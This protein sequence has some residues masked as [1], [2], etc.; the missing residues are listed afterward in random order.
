MQ[1]IL[2][3]TLVS[4]LFVLNGKSQGQK[5][6]SPPVSPEAAS[7][8]KASQMPVGHF[9]G[10][11]SVSVP[12]F[13]I[14]LND[15]EWPISLS[16][17]TGGIK[18]EEMASCAGLGWTLNATGSVNQTING[19]NDLLFDGYPNAGDKLSDYYAPNP[20]SGPNYTGGTAERRKYDAYK[21]IAEGQ[22][23]WQPDLF[24]YNAGAFS[25]KFFLDQ[26]GQTH[27]SPF[28]QLKTASVFGSHHLTSE[29][30]VEYAFDD[31]EY[32][33]YGACFTDNASMSN[34]LTKIKT[35]NG[36]WLSFF[37]DTLTYSYVARNQ[38]MICMKMYGVEFTGESPCTM[39]NCE[40]V[41]NTVTA[42]I[43]KKIISS[44][45]D[46]VTF[47][48]SSQPR[49]DIINGKVL[50]SVQVFNSLH[51]RV[52]KLNLKHSYIG[53]TDS[54][55]ACRLMLDS[56]K[57][58]ST[59]GDE[60]LLYAYEYDNL[61]PLPD[62][63]SKSQDV[64][65]YYNGQANNTLLP[66]RLDFNY[67]GANRSI[68]FAYAKAGSLKK[69]TYSTGGY[70]SFEYEPNDHY[71]SN[72]HVD[73]LGY[74]A[75]P[76][77][78]SSTSSTVSYTVTIPTNAANITLL[79]YQYGCVAT[80]PPDYN[81]NCLITFSGNGEY[82]EWD[83]AYPTNEEM[84]NIPAGSYTV[85][86][87]TTGGSYGHF[88]VKY[89][90]DHSYTFTGNLPTGGLR[91][92]STSIATDN[93][94]V[95]EVIRYRYKLFND[96]SRS[97]GQV[98]LEPQFDYYH[99]NY[100]WW[101]TCG[102]YWGHFDPD[103]APPP[104]QLIKLA[105]QYHILR[106]NSVLPLTN[107]LGN[108]TAYTN[109]SE[110]AGA[111]Y[112]LG[113][114]EYTFS[115]APDQSH[116]VGFPS[117]LQTLKDWQRGQLLTKRIYKAVSP[118]QLT[119]QS[120]DENFYNEKNY[121]DYWAKLYSNT[122]DLPDYYKGLGLD[123]QYQVPEVH[124]GLT[125]FPA[126]FTI[127]DFHLD[128]K[129][130]RLDSSRQTLYDA[131][132]NL[133]HLTKY[134]YNSSKHVLLT[135]K[136]TKTSKGIITAETYTYPPDHYGSLV[137]DT[138][139]ARYILS[140]VIT[141]TKTLANN[142]IS[143][144]ENEYYYWNNGKPLLK[145]MRSSTYTN[146]LQDD[147]TINKY[148]SKGNVVEFV[149]KNGITTS[150]VYDY[151]TSSPIAQVI[152]SDSTSIAYTSFEADG[153]GGWTGIDSSYISRGVPGITGSTSYVAGNLFLSKSALSSS[154][155]YIVSYWSANGY[156]NVNSSSATAGPTKGIWTYYQ[157]RVVNPASGTITIS[158]TGSI[159]E[160]RLY[161]EGAQMTTYTYDPLIGMTSKCEANSRITY[162]EYDKFNR[163]SII[164]D[165]NSNVI[166]KICYNYHGQPEECFSC[167]GINKK[168]INGV[169]EEG[170]KVCTSSTFVGDIFGDSYE[171][172]YHYEWSDQSWSLNYTEIGNGMCA[173]GM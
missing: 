132:G 26:Y 150:I 89:F 138:M 37:Y 168:V 29:S 14:K 76:Y 144:S 131:T 20:G 142:Q 22:Y 40:Y 69:V 46:S 164:R 153:T 6:G 86:I 173:L 103:L 38:E 54:S 166:K 58:E 30:G 45:G 52:Q 47:T 113:K 121:S 83:C 125:V 18:V 160:V 155:T 16:Y 25:G 136:E 104:C 112:E 87:T 129:W 92:K 42:K 157:H 95:P 61:V 117:T 15:F 44:N 13:T 9:T 53:N 97:S 78:N 35:P 110:A 90:L 33:Q 79:H 77:Y 167:S 66:S 49:Y 109:V 100:H 120:L 3:I 57:A 82:Y 81:E 148:D 158:G 10:T 141:N 134:S 98:S 96:T 31:P 165:Q 119:L 105:T 101:T 2:L 59:N 128:S 11:A 36:N 64:W 62:R 67:N 88:Q 8:F 135:G 161:P 84:V 43:L 41:T 169:C 1:K 127:N 143:K 28:G 163:L 154:G 51:Q 85:T 139:V 123:I 56:V 156:Y 63:L 147:I 111:G 4:L 34:F 23:D 146:T 107:M 72:Y 99:Y 159:D 116:S 60:Q 149:A 7:L 21:R 80:T 171:H 124:I 17:Q 68:N 162:Y 145:K 75:S 74:F 106:A 102:G 152:N 48:Y 115:Y 130:Y 32:Y 91:I 65:G 170:I 27:A 24:M 71:V 94:A 108:F 50:T 133:T 12:I 39:N 137:Y 172:T 118:T 140:P 114:T 122:S 55:T 73:S 126:E 151:S 70:S 19:H 93:S 5:I